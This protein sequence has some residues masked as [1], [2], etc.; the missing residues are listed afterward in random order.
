MY[1][2][3]D[4]PY[5]YPGTDVLKNIPGIRDQAALEAFEAV[6]TS[7]RSDEAL[8]TG[9]FSI[10][11]YRAIHHHLF[12][13][14][15]RWAGRFRTVR[16]GKDTSV[17]CY[18]EN[19]PAAMKKVFAALQAKACLRA[20]RSDDFATEAAHFLAGLNAIHPFREGNGRSQTTF[21]VLLAVHG[22]HPVRL[23]RLVPDRFLK[24]M[25]ASFHGGERMLADEIR[26]LVT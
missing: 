1:A 26:A 4:D 21:L 25:V 18:P 16:I 15:Y 7:Q 19:I 14:V 24:A 6:S 9:R 17:F 22:G 10:S 3:E 12:Q 11:H 13:D 20:L 8:P 2:A 5:C 23:E